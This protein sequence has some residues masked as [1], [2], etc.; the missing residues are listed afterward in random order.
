M[1]NP[2]SAHRLYPHHLRPTPHPQDL[3]NEHFLPEALLLPP[4]YIALIGQWREEP[5]GTP[6]FA[7][8]MTPEALRAAAFTVHFSGAKPWQAHDMES[9]RRVHTTGL[10][11]A[12]ELFFEIYKRWWELAL[13]VFSVQEMA[14]LLAGVI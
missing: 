4:L 9:F 11:R 14:E 8:V 2:L 13:E 7:G 5:Y 10:Y 1:S 3:L 12:H 6:G